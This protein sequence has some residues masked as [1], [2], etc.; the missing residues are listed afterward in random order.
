VLEITGNDIVINSVEI[1]N[2][3]IILGFAYQQ[4]FNKIGV[5]AEVNANLTT[6]GQRNVL[7]SSDPL[8]I[9]PVAGFQLDYNEKVYLR[10][11]INTIQKETDLA[12]TEFWSVNPNAGVGIKLG[13]LRLDY[14]FTNVGEQSNN[15]YSHIVSMVL[16]VNYDYWKKVL[17]N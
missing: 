17:K 4:R 6:D 8:S 15:T 3:S 10:G 5:L 7:V 11:G 1:T 13:A 2:P 14:A 9:D 16:D 12:G